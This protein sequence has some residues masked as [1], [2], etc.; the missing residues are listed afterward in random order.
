MFELPNAPRIS[1][2][3]LTD[4]TCTR[5]P[6]SKTSNTTVR[7][8]VASPFSNGACTVAVTDVSSPGASVNS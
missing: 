8:E 3:A 6:S 4:A 7:F 5:Y 2:E 1:V